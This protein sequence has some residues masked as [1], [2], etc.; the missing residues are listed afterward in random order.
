M[1]VKI[2]YG[3]EID[4][5]PEEV[6]QLFT[7]VSEKA[8]AFKT[9]T[10]HVEDAL[11]SEDLELVLPLIDKMRRT[12]ALMDHRLADIEMISAG[13]LNYKQGE[14]DVHAGRPSV[15]TAGVGVAATGTRRPT[16]DQDRTE[17]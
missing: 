11:D 4:E 3:A 7:Y 13:Y 15:D 17:A 5:V 10:E 9:Q 8:R 14:Q 2:S 6:E 12:I 16:H 1:R